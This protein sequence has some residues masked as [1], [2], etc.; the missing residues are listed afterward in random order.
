ML[1][2]GGGGQSETAEGIP[3]PLTIGAIPSE[4]TGDV[5]EAFQPVADYVGEELGVEAELYTATDYSGIIEAMRLPTKATSSPRAIATSR[6]WR[7]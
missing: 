5:V 7:T 6:V 1:L 3:N 4:D 2:V